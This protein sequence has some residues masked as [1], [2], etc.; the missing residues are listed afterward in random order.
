MP[1]WPF[2][3]SAAAAPPYQFKPETYGAAGD[4]I[5]AGDGSITGGTNTFSTPSYFF[6]AAT[7]IGKYIMINGAQGATN[8]PLIARITSVVGGSAVLSASAGNTAAA[9]SA[10]WATDDAPAFQ[11]MSDAMVAYALAHNYKAQAFLGDKLYGLVTLRQTTT[12]ALYNTHFPVGTPALNGTSRKLIF[13]V[14]GVGKAGQCQFWQSTIPNLQGSCL[15]SMSQAPG[16]ANATYGQQSVMGGPTGGGVF[17]GGFAN[18]HVVTEGITVCSPG[19]P[20]QIGLDFA[21]LGGWSWKEISAQTLQSVAGNAPNLPQ[22]PPLAAF[23]NTIGAGFRAPLAGNNDAVTGVRLAVEGYQTHGW[24][25]DHFVCSG[26]A[27][28]YQHIGILIDLTHGTSGSMHEVVI[29]GWSCENFNGALRCNGGGAGYVAVNIDLDTETNGGVDPTYDVAATGDLHGVI[30]VSDNGSRTSR[31][32]IVSGAGPNLKIT[33]EMIGP[34]HMAAPPAVPASGA[35]A[36]QVWRNASVVVHTPA[37]VT[38]S[39]VTID[40]TSTGLTM[41]AS[42]SLA[43]PQLPSGRTVALTYAGGA[44]T[45]DWWLGD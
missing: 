43:L 9:A 37:G 29:K 41:A 7:D 2:G 11:A 25:A 22:M 8:A 27:T 44:P 42:S 3:G 38:V 4:G 36:V 30:R 32:V 33:N 15:V 31:N 6:T 17:T 40:G 34:G 26:L 5:V 35:A 10:F 21:Y 24:I 20:N 12:P 23:Q 13:E 18:T 28:I 45:W 16:I 19:F 39:A 1:F 14:Y